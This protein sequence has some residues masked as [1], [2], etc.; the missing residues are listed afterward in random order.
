MFMFV[1]ERRSAKAVRM[2]VRWEDEALAAKPL[3]DA[4]RH[5]GVEPADQQYVNLFHEDVTGPCRLNPEAAPLVR[6]SQA[7]F[8]IVALGN[9]VAKVLDGLAIPYTKIVHPAARGKIRLRATYIA[10]IGH[11]LQLA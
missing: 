6:A 10:H 3:F 5:W 11:A 1:G 8:R 7:T 9:R 2:G 4:L